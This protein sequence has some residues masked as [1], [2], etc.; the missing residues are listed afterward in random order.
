MNRNLYRPLAAV[1]ATLSTVGFYQGQ[2][3]QDTLAPEASQ[4]EGVVL[5][6]VIDLAKDRKTPVAVSTVK[7]EEIQLRAVGNVE[8]PNILKN[9]P[10]VYVA[11]ES[12]GFGDSQIFVRGFSQSNT[13]F[14]LNG[15]PINGM[16]DG[17]MYWSNWAGISDI[18]NMVQVQ[19][20]LGSSKLAISSVGGTINIITKA[21]EKNEGGFVRFIVGN[22]SYKKGTVS[23]DT[24]MNDKGWAFSFLLDYWTADKKYADGTKGAGQNYFFSVGKKA[25]KHNFNF[26]ITGAPQWHD[27]NFSKDMALYDRYGRRFNNNY[28]YLNGEYLTSRRN[29]YH[30]PIAN[31]TWDW[32]INDTSSLSTVIYG[33]LGRGG[34]TGTYGNGPGYLSDYPDGDP[35]LQRGAYKASTGLIDWDY[36]VAQNKLIPGGYSK[37]YDGTML[38]S[39]VNNHIWYGGVVNYENNS[40]KNVSLNVG[41][42]IRFYTGTHFRQLTDLLGLKGRIEDFG[43]NPNHTVTATFDPNP[44]SS[45][46]NYADKN[47]RIDYDYSEDINYQGLFGQAEWSNNKL[48]AFVQGAISNQSYKRYDRGNFATERVSDVVKKT[49]YNIKAG[50]SWK[51]AKGNT[52][53]VNVGK[54]SRQPFLDNI[55]TSYSDNT[56][57]TDDDVNNEEIV[58]F[59]AGYRFEM[60]NLQVNINAYS[61]TWE[62]RFLGAGGEYTAADGTFYDDVTYLFTN[63]SELHQGIEL[64]VK[65]R[66][67]R[68]MT[69]HGFATFGNWE[70]NGTTPVNVRDNTNQTIVANL[71]TDLKETKV[72]SAPQTSAG[73]G[74]DYDIIH[75]KL[76]AYV[77]WNYFANFYGFVDVEDAATAS[78][79]GKVYQPEKLN[80]YSLFDLG[81][82]YNFNLGGQRFQL[83]G[84]VYNLFDKEYISQKDNYGYYLGNG[85]TFNL[86]IKF[87]F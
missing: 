23:Y 81:A 65:Y 25:G 24:G 85:T 68:D 70:Y 3:T 10:N 36:V 18:A 57:I 84:N 35:S 30:K 75:D 32:E 9:T 42:D 29:Y 21:A 76:H 69:I 28:G 7:R 17:K 83:A 4:I 12:G 37:G 15:Q 44:W 27:Q 54:Y 34:G 86:A 14:L 1:L 19:R 79:A 5:H 72:G 73:L 45:L 22:G 39:S 66:P 60:K 87:M 13:A 61:T 48:S 43:G 11:N 46:F 47:E 52:I 40:I 50:A 74:I 33:S 41:T 77:N 31:L 8:F 64:E 78:L 56:A 2:E 16:E 51:F 82:S 26:L 58:G 63:I 53:F 6:G 38:R 49:G 20:G 59:E 67:M 71:T 80:N 62:N 55:F